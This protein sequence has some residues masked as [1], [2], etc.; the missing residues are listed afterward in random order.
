MGAKLH[1]EM[2]VLSEQINNLQ[3]KNESGNVSTVKRSLQSMQNQYSNGQQ[4]PM[5]QQQQSQSMQQPQQQSQSMQQPQQQQQS[6]QQQ[7]QPQQQQYYSSNMMMKRQM[8]GRNNYNAQQPMNAYSQSYNSY[9]AQSG[10]AQPIGQSQMMKRQQQLRLAQ[11]YYPSQQ[12]QQ[13]QQ[14]QQHGY[15][16]MGHNMQMGGIVMQPERFPHFEQ[17]Q[18][19]DN[20]GFDESQMNRFQPIGESN[21]YDEIAEGQVMGDIEKRELK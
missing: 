7:Q 8:G 11:P 17:P 13:Q 3:C 4:Q 6:L 18:Y 2:E 15:P 10:Y 1:E 12:G 21:L 19:Y 5:R 14:Q 9:R 16:Y 20:I